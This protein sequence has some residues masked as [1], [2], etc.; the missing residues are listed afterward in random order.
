MR[1]IALFVLLGSTMLAAQPAPVASRGEKRAAFLK[2][3]DRPCVDP[4]AA[5][6]PMT[7]NGLR[8]VQ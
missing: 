8:L 3:I 6:R 1:R 5:V 7:A 2:L 4:A